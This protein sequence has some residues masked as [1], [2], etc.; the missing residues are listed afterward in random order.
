[1]IRLVYVICIAMAT[2]ASRLVRRDDCIPAEI[3][4]STSNKK[5]IICVDESIGSN[6]LAQIC[7]L[8]KPNQ[9]DDLDLAQSTIYSHNQFSCCTANF[10]APRDVVD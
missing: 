1:M 2:G 10:H 9:P 5:E 7:T 3:I 8:R 6:I 4:D